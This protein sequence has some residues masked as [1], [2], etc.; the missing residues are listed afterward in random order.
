MSM[1]AGTCP[2]RR[3][4]CSTELRELFSFQRSTLCRQERSKTKRSET[5]S[6]QPDDRA[7]HALHHASNLTFLALEERDLKPRIRRQFFYLVDATGGRHPVI[8]LNPFS[9][10]RNNLIRENPGDLSR[11]GSGN[12]RTRVQQLSCEVPVI[13]EH[14]EAFGI[15]VQTSN[16]V[17]PQ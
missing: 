3:R 5:D 6:F 4:T 12:V 11:I 17:Q 8:K 2:F 1:C 16:R 10:L 14:N 9:K 15:E 13:G 7:S